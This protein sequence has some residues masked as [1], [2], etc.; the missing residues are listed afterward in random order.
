M[1]NYE[2]ARLLREI[3]D[4]LEL[5]DETGFKVA[6]Y[7]KAARSLESMKDN[8]ESVWSDGR[9]KSIPGVGKAIAKKIEEYLE[10]GQ[11]ETHKRLVGAITPGLVE[12]LQ[13][14]GIGPKTVLL[15]HQKLNVSSIEDLEKAARE[16]QV[17]RLPRM[18]ATSENNILKAIERYRKRSDRIPLGV[19][20]PLAEEI[21]NYL[22]RIEGVENLQVAGSLR[23]GRDT[24][25]D[26]DVL[27]TSSSPQKVIDAFA[28]MPLV[29][30][31]LWKGGT[32]ASVI[33]GDTIQV[34]LRIVDHRS[35]GTVLQYFTGSKDHNVKL[36]NL[37]LERGYSLSEYSLT[38]L[39]DDE[40]LFFDCE[41]DLYGRLGLPWISPELREDRGEIEAALDGTLPRLVELSD[42][43]GDLHVH[44]DWSDG[45]NSIEEM[46]EAAQALGYE[47][48]AIC[49]HSPGLGIASGL[50]IERL[51]EK[52]RTIRELNETLEGFTLI[53]G[54]EVDIRADG[55]LDYPDEVLAECDLVVAAIHSAY[56]QSE[57]AIN[58]RIIS[59]MEN[60]HVDIIAH[61]TGR[62][63]GE[64]EPYLVDVELILEAALRT[65]TIMEI[66]AHPVRLDL[67][68]R[69][70]R[71]AKEI[72]VKVAINSDAHSIRG[73]KVMKFGVKTA[74]RGWLEP[75]DVANASNLKELMKRLQ[76]R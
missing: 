25:G 18:G 71:R 49:D 35:F 51:A 13:I 47:Y 63:I 70:A 67:N 44:S 56:N 17:R 14:S 69:W 34:D 74:Q 32:K 57:R 55:R 60:E 43:K 39:R 2:V 29:Q 53:A 36:R 4:L 62:K 75:E 42:I 26:I 48:M 5:R 38:R 1:K 22:G 61:P 73:L 68:D 3:G 50:S 8:V 7:R 31:V 6:A 20:L 11:I 28:K 19:A 46:V 33:A 59:A 72:G 52:I 45:K 27:A 15:L 65:E 66:N 24:V 54:T 9:L 41:E 76:K 37:A 23:R 58:S 64:R 30:E 21:L 40:E 16:H 10:T 12:L